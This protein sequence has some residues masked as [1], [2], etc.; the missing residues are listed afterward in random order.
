MADIRDGDGAARDGDVGCRLV[1]EMHHTA[2][3]VADLD[4][5]TA[6]YSAAFDVDVEVAAELPGFRLAMLRAPAGWRLELFE[7]VGASR[8][9][10]SS[11]PL[12]V[13][14]HHGLTHLAMVVD[15][16]EAQHDRLVAIG[17]ES[18]WDPRPS[19]EPGK[20]MAFIRDP[21][22]NLIELIGPLSDSIVAAHPGGHAP[23]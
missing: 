14:R 4:D 21:E 11:T 7:A 19:P 10:D 20:A 15:D 18:V 8:T 12:T 13:M 23:H 2:L 16:V 9:V 6:W 3:S 17:A 5:A 1:I 22:G